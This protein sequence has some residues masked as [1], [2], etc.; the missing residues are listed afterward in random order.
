MAATC[1]ARTRHHASVLALVVMV[2]LIPSSHAARPRFAAVGSPPAS[3][4][5]SAAAPTCS[6]GGPYT[7]QCDGAVLTSATASDIDGDRLTFRWT[8]DCDGDAVFG[9]LADGTF[10]DDSLLNERGGLTCSRLVA[11]RTRG[12]PAVLRAAQ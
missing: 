6:A 12:W 5:H 9:E 2:V 4:R 3:A 7:A 10:D 1:W 8:S 11:R